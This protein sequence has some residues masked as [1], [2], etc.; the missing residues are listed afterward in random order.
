[1]VFFNLI[2]VFHFAQIMVCGV[3]AHQCVLQ[4]VLDLSD[5]GYYVHV[6]ADAVSSQR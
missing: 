3:E 4:S 2:C 1:M 6:V 5:L